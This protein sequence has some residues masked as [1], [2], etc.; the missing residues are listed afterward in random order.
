MD[1][2]ERVRLIWDKEAPRFDKR[3]TLF[4]KVL[5]SGSRQWVCSQARGEVLE[6]AVGT[7]RNLPFYRPNVKLT[8]IELSPSMLELARRR[9]HD[10]GRE[11]DLRI[12]DAQALDFSDESFDTVVV[13]ISL[14]SIPDDRK[15]VAEINRALRPGGKLLLFEH[16]ASP[17]AP[18]RAV[19]CLLDPLAVR[20]EGDHL[21][22]EPLDHL[23][24]EGFHID[25][26]ERSKLGIVERIAATKPA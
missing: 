1:E 7:G 15:A 16:V 14:C 21:V 19:Q 10:L 18:V 6:I 11:A 20:L 17:L 22:R 2:T 5:F 24:A 12:G 26:A 4:E 13:T 23:K 8:G 3:I 25:V 9:A